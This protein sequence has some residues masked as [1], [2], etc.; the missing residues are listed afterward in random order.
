MDT[1]ELRAVMKALDIMLDSSLSFERKL[2]RML[3]FVTKSL[4]SMNGS[5]MILEDDHV[6]IKA[7]MK[8]ELIGKRQSLSEDSISIR[9]FNESKALKIDDFKKN[10]KLSS[11][12]RRPEENKSAMFISA[13][14]MAQSG[15]VG[16]F[17]IS[18]K[19]SKEP[20]TKKETDTLYK[21]ILR[22]S[23]FVESAKLT[24]DLQVGEMKLK[25]ANR[26]LKKLEDLK[27]DLVN[28]VVHDMKNP[29]S[30]VSANLKLFEDIDLDDLGQTYLESASI[31][32]KTLLRMI[33]NLL[34]ISRMEEDSITLEPESIDVSGLL[35]EMVDKNRS[36]FELSE[37]TTQVKILGERKKLI[38]DRSLIER[39]LTNLFSNAIEHSPI[40]GF[41]MITAIFPEDRPVV[42]IRVS[43]QGRG[44]PE[45]DQKNI[46][47]KFYQGGE[48]KTRC[49]SG[50]GLSFCEMVV[51][52]HKGKIWVESDTD[53]G[54]VF[55][56]DL[57]LDG[58][59]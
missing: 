19:T 58:F 32:T 23:P 13:P 5:I 4:Q 52:T 27:R 8:P 17:N 36:V 57:P 48:S 54:S 6:V 34:D 25:K 3:G 49:G 37:L 31:G 15:P 1:G 53:R 41:I 39:V 50:L 28:M 55:V 24:H 14:I 35:S 2:G 51:R 21:W 45:Q 42:E 9:V 16:V 44:V 38:A 56:F 10:P 20:Y 11:L 26:M 18:D 7:S 46:F 22:I 29:L 43:D 59:S 30:E 47:K 33:N 12:M 40:K